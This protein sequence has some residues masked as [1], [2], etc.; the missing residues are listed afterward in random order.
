MTSSVV[1]GFST[2]LLLSVFESWMIA[3]HNQMVI[4]L[5]P[6]LLDWYRMILRELSSLDGYFFLCLD[7]HGSDDQVAEKN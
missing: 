1:G 3:E 2:S 7:Y 5:S 6:F 4:L